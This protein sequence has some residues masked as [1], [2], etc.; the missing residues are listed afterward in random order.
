M[1]LFERSQ[2]PPLYHLL[3]LS[4]F[5]VRALFKGFAGLV[6]FVGEA[7]ILLRRPGPVE[8]LVG[9]AILAGETPRLSII[10]RW[11]H[12]LWYR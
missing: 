3:M 12:E 4:F 6:F 7:P 10:W 5:D 9:L 2:A 11:M 8:D 1:K